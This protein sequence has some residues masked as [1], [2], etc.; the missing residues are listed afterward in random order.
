MITIFAFSRKLSCLLALIVLVLAS[1]DTAAQAQNVMT[2]PSNVVSP[3]PKPV[4]L[5]HLYLYFLLHQ[6][7]LDARAASEEAKGLDGKW[8]RNHLQTHLGFSDDDYAQVRTSSTRLGAKVT[9]LNAQAKAFRSDRFSS[10]VEDL[11]AL[12]SQ[13]DAYLNAEINHLNLVLSPQNKAALEAF[14]T[15][16]FAPK[17][18]AVKPSTIGL[19]APAEVQK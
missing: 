7:R 17:A 16:F 2:Q 3:Q 1:G 10:H 13:R 8:M 9:V 12:A 4:P 14:M 18:A 11:K 6:N 19:L 5:A 15:R